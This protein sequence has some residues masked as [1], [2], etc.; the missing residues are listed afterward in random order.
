MVLVAFTG[1][2]PTIA[3]DVLTEESGR[4]SWCLCFLFPAGYAR[5]RRLSPRSPSCMFQRTVPRLRSV[6]ASKE[7]LAAPCVT[8]KESGVGSMSLRSIASERCFLVVKVS[9]GHIYTHNISHLVAGDIMYER[10]NSNVRI[11]TIATSHNSTVFFSH[12][13]TFCASLC[14]E[15]HVNTNIISSENLFLYCLLFVTR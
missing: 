5:V 9:V 13:H 6:E 11:L 14:H 8:Q 4:Y 1:L 3:G 10:G 7:D 2:T 15:L 12:V